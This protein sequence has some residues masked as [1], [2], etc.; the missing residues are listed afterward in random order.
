[1]FKP[2]SELRRSK[3]PAI[4]AYATHGV[5]RS[6]VH[7][8]MLN[9]FTYPVDFRNTLSE[10]FLL[11]WETRYFQ[12]KLRDG[13]ISRKSL[14][15][16]GKDVEYIV[17]FRKSIKEVFAPGNVRLS[18]RKAKVEYNLPAYVIVEPLVS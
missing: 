15:G 2:F 10:Y 12:E 3:I 6:T 13:I 16:S 1:M 14:D 18:F 5:K 11:H 7:Y 17:L 8:M 4:A 9:H